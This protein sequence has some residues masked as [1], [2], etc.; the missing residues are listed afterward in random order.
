MIRALGEQAIKELVIKTLRRL[1]R[2]GNTLD[3]PC[4]F[5]YEFVETEGQLL[6]LGAFFLFGSL[7]LP[8]ALTSATPV[9]WLIALLSLTLLR[10]LPVW[11][12]LG[13]LS[14]KSDTRLFLGWFGP[15]GLASLLFISL[16]VKDT[17][18]PNADAVIHI[19]FITVFLSIFLHGM[20]AAPLA[21]LYGQRHAT[22]GS[23]GETTS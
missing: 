15:R 1:K 21:R 18:L 2:F 5:L 10:M 6:T 14:L 23:P 16:V 12:S 17:M 3:R 20:S 9:Y 7:F 19:V 4:H 13:G 22:N 8:E 11:L